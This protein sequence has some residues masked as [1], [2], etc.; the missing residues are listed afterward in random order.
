MEG[1]ESMRREGTRGKLEEGME[2]RKRES[3][4]SDGYEMRRSRG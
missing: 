1:M 2:S 4:I 3:R